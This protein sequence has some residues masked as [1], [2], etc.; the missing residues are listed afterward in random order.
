MIHS[1]TR[2]IHMHALP[3][4]AATFHAIEDIL[5][6]QKR[7]GWHILNFSFSTSPWDT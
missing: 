7:R 1:E 2:N 3:L 4:N 6:E 5:G